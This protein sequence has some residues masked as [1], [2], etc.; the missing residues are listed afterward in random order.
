MPPEERAKITNR[1]VYDEEN[2]E[3]KLK[4]IAENK[5]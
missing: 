1:C 4:P 2:N 3:W 5:T